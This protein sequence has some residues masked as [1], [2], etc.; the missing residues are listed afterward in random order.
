V[1]VRVAV[2]AQRLELRLPA[3]TRRELQLPGLTRITMGDASIVDV[4]TQG[5]GQL[6]FVAGQ[7][8]KAN[9]LVWTRDA[10]RFEYVVEVTAAEPSTEVP[11]ELVVGLQ[12]V[13]TFPGITDAKIADAAVCDVQRLGAQELLLLPQRPGRTTLQVWNGE[14]SQSRS[15]VVRA[16]P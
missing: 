16:A 15:L 9:V 7:P 11:L 14:A 6:L 2:L 10:R 12:Q 3:G 5:H 13:L 8:G 4:T 1:V